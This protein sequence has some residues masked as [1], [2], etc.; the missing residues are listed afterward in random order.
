MAKGSTQDS[1]DD[2]ESLCPRA[3]SVKDDLGRSPMIICACRTMG[4]CVLS[5]NIG[6]AQPRVVTHVHLFLAELCDRAILKHRPKIKRT[7][8]RTGQTIGQYNSRRK[9][10]SGLF[11]HQAKKD[12]SRHAHPCNA[13]SLLSRSFPRPRPPSSLSY[14]LIQS[15]IRATKTV[16]LVI[17]SILIYRKRIH[18]IIIT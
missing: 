1:Q 15:H 12:T 16:V 9:K 2:I 5:P 3:F 14:K 13:F 8:S 11:Q 18:V 17:L 6:C 7:T 4:V 10:G